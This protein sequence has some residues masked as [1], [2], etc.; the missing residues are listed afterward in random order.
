[1]T[2][3]VITTESRPV[4][5]ANGWVYT[6]PAGTPAPADITDIQS[7]WIKLGTISE[8]GAAWTPPSEDTTEIG[9]WES[10]YPARIVT[11]KLSTSVKFSMME[12]DRDTIPFAMG[13]GTFEDTAT[14]VI[15]H[16]PKPG[17]SVERALLVQ[18]L[19]D[20]CT[21]AVYYGRGRVSERED[22]TFK[23]DE[24][25]MLGVTFAIVGDPAL[26]PFQ[27][28]FDPAHFP[29]GTPIVAT[30]ATAGT[31]GF[32]TPAGAT[33]PANLTALQAGG[34]TASP[35]TAWTTGQYVALGTG[36]AN[37]SGTAWASGMAP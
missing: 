5:G 24:A 4:V 29:S 22:T 3:P 7:P 34:I 23:K 15:Y 18:V 25:A 10:M 27:L 26:D 8:D 9:I 35:T 33:P 37:W 36:N 28:L 14:S 11:T 13:G 30:G 6:A 20:P 2:A 19:D 21:V 17:E 12:W 32:F 1:M 16:P 31:P